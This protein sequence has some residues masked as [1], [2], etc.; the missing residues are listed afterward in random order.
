MNVTTEDE[1]TTDANVDF[2]NDGGRSLY[3]FDVTQKDLGGTG[4]E[5]DVRIANGRE[6]RTRSLEL[7]H[8]GLFGAYTNGDLLLAKSSD[9]GE[10]RLAV[11][12]PLFSYTTPYTF[13]ASFDHLTQD[14][15]VYEHGAVASL[16]RQRHRELAASYGDVLAGTTDFT[17]RLVAGADFLTDSFQPRSGLAPDDRNFKF[18][19]SGIDSQQF[20]FIKFDHVDLGLR[21][22][23]F[24]LGMH[25]SLFA[26]VTPS[27]VVRFR[28]DNS[29]GHAFGDGAFVLTRLIATTR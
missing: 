20:D 7:L 8:P 3:D 24:N 26:G 9:G 15:R 29:Y 11:E 22:Q 16:F 1:F 13:S 17:I 23:D 25:V 12:R 21:E 6:R 2:S 19:E 28:S 10:Q 14:A 5:A 18:F 4:A 27:H